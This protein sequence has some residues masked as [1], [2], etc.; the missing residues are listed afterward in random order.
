VSDLEHGPW[1]PPQEYFFPQEQDAVK[2]QV[3]FA[4]SVA[5]P[6]SAATRHRRAA[7]AIPTEWDYG[8]AGPP[9]VR[10]S[11]SGPLCQA[12]GLRSK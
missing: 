3:K 9:Q 11:A 7:T 5:V 10:L 8:G 4:Q 1:P 6:A 12:P 2:R